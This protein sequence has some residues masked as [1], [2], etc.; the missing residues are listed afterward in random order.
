MDER[1]HIAAVAVFIV[2]LWMVSQGD[3]ATF[4]TEVSAI[5][6]TVML[7]ASARR[8]GSTAWT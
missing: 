7:A 5:R 1:I 2:V 8:G 6:R 4:L 3:Y